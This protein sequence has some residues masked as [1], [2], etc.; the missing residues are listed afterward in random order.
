MGIKSHKGISK[1]KS[2]IKCKSKKKKSQTSNKT[3][4]GKKSNINYVAKYRVWL[5]TD[6]EDNGNITAG[7]GQDTSKVGPHSTWIHT[8]VYMYIG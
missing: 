6:K 4:R 5:G 1:E 7:T 3:W 2:K 8:G